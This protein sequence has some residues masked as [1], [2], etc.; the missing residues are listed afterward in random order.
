MNAQIDLCRSSETARD[1]GPTLGSKS[2]LALAGA[3]VLLLGCQQDQTAMTTEPMDPAA[4]QGTRPGSD[5][6]PS[7]GPSGVSGP[8]SPGAASDA[9]GT[10]DD[11]TDDGTAGAN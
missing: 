9:G 11:T 6:S 2:L 1:R 5:T 7:G 8:G 3:A 4:I 10:G